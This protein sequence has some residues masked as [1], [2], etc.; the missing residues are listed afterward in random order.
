MIAQGDILVSRYSATATD[1]VGY[2]GMPPTGKAIERQPCRCS[3]LERKD[4]REWAV[5][6]DM[7]TLRQLGHVALPGGPPKR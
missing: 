2:M 5:R 6:D 1:S 7:G 4:R 3:A